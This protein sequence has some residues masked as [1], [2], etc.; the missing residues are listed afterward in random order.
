M[1]NQKTEL[2][3]P[4]EK[5]FGF[6]MAGATGFLLVLGAMT[7]GRLSPLLLMLCGGFTFFT[8]T[9]PELLKKP[10]Y[11]WARFGLVLHRFMTP[12]IMGIIFYGLFAPIGFLLRWR[13]IDILKQELNPDLKSYW[14]DRTIVGPPREKMKFPF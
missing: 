8:L 12:V 4:S 2:I 7:T 11:W 13:K 9:K 14:V 10:N 1:K 5:S 3:L 6:T